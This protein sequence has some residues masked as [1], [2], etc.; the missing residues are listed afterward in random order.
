MS[1]TSY[2]LFVCLMPWQNFKTVVLDTSS[3]QKNAHKMTS[4][5]LGV[6]ALRKTIEILDLKYT[7][8]CS[9]IAV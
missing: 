2:L 6:I 1:L 4:T 8:T 7:A 5:R 3:Y 9:V